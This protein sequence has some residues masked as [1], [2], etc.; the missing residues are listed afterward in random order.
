[1]NS[2]L[3]YSTV[4][5][6]EQGLM[7]WSEIVEDAYSA[8]IIAADNNLPW[9]GDVPIDWWDLEMFALRGKDE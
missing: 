1:M 6:Y 4:S 7:P 3:V 5:S 9:P 2:R 8:L